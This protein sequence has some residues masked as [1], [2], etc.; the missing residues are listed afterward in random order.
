M[1]EPF[2]WMQAKR[3]PAVARGQQ[4]RREAM[5]RTELEDRAGLLQRLGHTKDSARARLLGNLAWDFDGRP[6]PLTSADV[7]VMVDRIFGGSA[8]KPGARARGGSR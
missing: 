8:G 4:A 3:N 2:D 7:D 6:A 5:Y 1:A